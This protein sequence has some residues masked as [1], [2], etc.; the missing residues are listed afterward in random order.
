M[1]RSHEGR[2]MSA[3]APVASEMINRV[4]VAIREADILELA[5]RYPDLEVSVIRKKADDCWGDHLSM[6]RAAIEAMREPTPLELYPGVHAY[7][8]VATTC[9]PVA[10]RAGWNA[11]IDAALS[12][13]NPLSARG[14]T[15]NAEQAGST[16]LL[17]VEPVAISNP[18]QESTGSGSKVPTVGS[19]GP[20]PTESEVDQ[21]SVNHSNLLPP[22]MYPPTAADKPAD[23]QSP[24]DA[25]SAG[26][27]SNNREGAEQ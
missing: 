11:V 18:N 19:D 7:I 12:K 20:S 16:Q 26:P 9:R 13:A 10:F 22:T 21:I 25:T 27:H 3:L 17:P 1:A 23:A 5:K 6:A 24:W 2:S 14:T 8:E 4:A 15:S